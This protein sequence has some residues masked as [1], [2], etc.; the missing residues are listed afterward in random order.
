VSL[1]VTLPLDPDQFVGV[2]LVL[3]RRIL[4]HPE[5]EG[6]RTYE[7][8]TSQIGGWVLSDAGGDATPLAEVQVLVVERGLSTITDAQGRFKFLRVPHGNYTLRAIAPGG[9]AE[10]RIEVPGESYD[11]IVAGQMDKEET[12]GEKGDSGGSRSAGK[13]RRR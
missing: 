6:G 10:R 2:P 4:V 12:S 13:S 7:L 9:I 1:V 8:T 11:V 3:T 5:I